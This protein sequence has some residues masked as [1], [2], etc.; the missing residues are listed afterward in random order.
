[1]LTELKL[2]KCSVL[3]SRCSGH[4]SLADG[5]ACNQSLLMTHSS[6]PGG[7]HAG[8]PVDLN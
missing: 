5:S 1:M 8:G 6:E 4:T 7:K 2:F 3:R